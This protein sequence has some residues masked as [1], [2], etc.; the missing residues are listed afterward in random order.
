MRTLRPQ[1]CDA[2][3]GNHKL[4]ALQLITY[5]LSDQIN[6]TIEF[7]D[8]KLGGMVIFVLVVF[9]FHRLEILSNQKG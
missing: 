6:V 5:E 4:K 7:L 9:D 3:L 1:L 2:F 8:P